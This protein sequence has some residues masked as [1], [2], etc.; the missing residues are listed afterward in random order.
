MTVAEVA[1]GNE[2]VRAF[3]K[4]LHLWADNGVNAIGI[5]LIRPA[6]LSDASGVVVVLQTARES[7]KRVWRLGPG[8]DIALCAGPIV[9]EPGNLLAIPASWFAQGAAVDQQVYLSLEEMREVFALALGGEASASHARLTES[10][11]SLTARTRAA[12]QMSVASK[13]A[14]LAYLDLQLRKRRAY[15]SRDATA[16]QQA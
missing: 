11:E 5:K 8:S 14:L 4:E 10:Y 12:A 1:Y 3:E 16:P 13:G 15:A 6:G 7:Q 2:T 9:E